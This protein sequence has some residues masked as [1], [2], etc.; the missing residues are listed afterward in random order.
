MHTYL[1]YQAEADVFF[2]W[3]K[4]LLLCSMKR[5]E[6]NWK[7]LKQDFNRVTSCPQLTNI[8]HIV[9]ILLRI[10]IF[11]QFCFFLYFKV[12]K[13]GKNHFVVFRKPPAWKLK[14]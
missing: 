8:N 3:I 5:G 9:L 1:V 14:V 4:E 10:A 7:L 13:F 11:K 12:L 2:G 6:H